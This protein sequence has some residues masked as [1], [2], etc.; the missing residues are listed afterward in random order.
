MPNSLT[1]I[2]CLPCNTVI[3]SPSWVDTTLFCSAISEIGSVDI[4]SRRIVSCFMLIW[5]TKIPSDGSEKY[6]NQ[7]YDIETIY[8]VKFRVFVVLAVMYPHNKRE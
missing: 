7:H 3:V 8:G 6:N 5:V 4:N 1:L 2:C